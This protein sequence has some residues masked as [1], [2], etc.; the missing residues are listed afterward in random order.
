MPPPREQPPGRGTTLVCFALPEEAAPFR[1][2]LPP[3]PDLAI[4]VTGMGARNSERALLPA[5]AQTNP[6]V[7]LT[8]GFAGGL[9]PALDVGQ[10]VFACD[11]SCGLATKLQAAGAREVR[12]H[13]AD[14]IAASALAKKTLR[15]S[16]GADV[17]EMESGLI[18]QICRDRGIPAA[19]VRVVSDHATE[20]LPLD[21][22]LLVTA[23]QKLDYAKLA[24]T[25]LK[26]P[27]R[28]PALL[29]L[30]RQTRFAASELA[31]VLAAVLGV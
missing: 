29:R 18:R 16:T 9:D 2:A 28:I 26:S 12:F 8:C 31:K 24:A 14:R 17:V 27:S 30:Q 22:N 10:V 4:L 5:L 13:C 19:T 25:L 7:I 23:D 21:F 15:D 3:R 20:D 1:R 11:A 6:A